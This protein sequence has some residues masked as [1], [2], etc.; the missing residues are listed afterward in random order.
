MPTFFGDGPPPEGI[1]EELRP[2]AREGDAYLPRGGNG[3]VWRFENGEWV[4][5]D[6]QAELQPE[7][8]R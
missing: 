6:W 8:E 7:A 5:L 1:A 3:E 2:Y 4:R